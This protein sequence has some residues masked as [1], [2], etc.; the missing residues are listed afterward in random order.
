M[1]TIVPERDFSAV[2]VREAMSGEVSNRVKFS[3]ALAWLRVGRHD[4]PVFPA[5]L[6]SIWAFCWSCWQPL[7]RWQNGSCP[8]SLQTEKWSRKIG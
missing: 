3:R 7:S 1:R 8:V 5:W 4:L 2:E 6:P